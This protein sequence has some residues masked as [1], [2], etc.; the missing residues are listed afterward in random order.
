[1]I[2]VSSKP[3]NIQSCVIYRA[4]LSSGACMCPKAIADSS[5]DWFSKMERWHCVTLWK[6]PLF[7]IRLTLHMNQTVIKHIFKYE[8][9]N[10]F[11]LFSD[12][13]QCKE[14]NGTEYEPERNTDGESYEVSE[15]SVYIIVSRDILFRI[16][17]AI[18][19][20]QERVLVFKQ[21]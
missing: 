5:P 1:M 18:W 8:P 10:P 3:W 4:D 11:K 16:A 2:A 6:M 7:I 20:S 15:S 14:W 17:K 21:P 13:A 9:L 12:H 19:W